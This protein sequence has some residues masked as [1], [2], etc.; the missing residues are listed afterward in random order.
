MAFFILGLTA[1]GGRPQN[2]RVFR[3]SQG[4]IIELNRPSGQQAWRRRGWLALVGGVHV[5]AFIGW[6]TPQRPVAASRT[7]H[8]PVTYILAPLRRPPPERPEAAR[9]PPQPAR[10]PPAAIAAIPAPPAPSMSSESPQPD[11]GQ[12]P[13]AIT[14]AAPPP[15]PFALP[16]KPE[17]DL[18]Q[19]A[20]KS[21]IAVDRQ[22]RKE[23]W[24]QRDRKIVNDTTALA[25]AIAKAYVG[26][27]GGAMEEVVM[28]DGTRMTKWR[29][30][31]GGTACFYAASN[32]YSGGRDPFRDAGKIRVAACP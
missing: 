2:R 24:T 5:L 11:A 18:K 9:K 3:T 19:R 21:A 8:A 16:V 4:H 25:A 1:Q 26:G 28:G 17:D 27:G 23:A 30:P 22:L 32:N 7:V 15:D 10:R 20:L 12:Q 14:Q 6:Q 13:Q 29:M 31:G